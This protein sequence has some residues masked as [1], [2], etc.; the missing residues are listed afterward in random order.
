M[1]DFRQ[2]MLVDSFPFSEE[3]GRESFEINRSRRL[4]CFPHVGLAQINGLCRPFAET[5]I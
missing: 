3:V 4:V 1:A 2:G 5:D